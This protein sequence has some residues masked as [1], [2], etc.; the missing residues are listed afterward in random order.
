M[1]IQTLDVSVNRE[2]VPKWM[3]NEQDN[4]PIVIVHKAPSSF[5]FNTLIA[6]PTLKMTIDSDG[7]SNGGETDIQIDHS[8]LVKSMVVNIKNL[9]F[10]MEGKSFVVKTAGDLFGVYVPAEVNGLV[11]EIGNYLATLLQKK[12]VD[13][14]N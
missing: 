1:I 4:N 3:N 6:K 14:K 5:L 13:V 9:E 11:D 2:Y 8:K 12:V 7:N 10:D